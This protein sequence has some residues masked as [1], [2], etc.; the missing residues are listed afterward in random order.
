MRTSVIHVTLA[1]KKPR[2]I[3]SRVSF[4]PARY[5]YILIHSP[6]RDREEKSGS[7]WHILPALSR[8]RAASLGDRVHSEL[9]YSGVKIDFSRVR[10]PF[11]KSI[12]EIEVA[13]VSSLFHLT[14]MNLFQFEAETTE[15]GLTPML[16]A[17]FFFLNKTKVLVIIGVSDRNHILFLQEGEK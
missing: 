8:R 6:E 5:G 15:K 7:T 12:R 17:L 10:E 3:V 4:S 16:Q 2:H 11:G 1:K 9:S 14:V 13:S